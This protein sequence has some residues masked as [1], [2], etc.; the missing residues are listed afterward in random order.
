M[1]WTREQ[2]EAIESRG[3]NLLLAA[4]AGSGKTAVLV[5]R[6]VSLILKDKVDVESLLVMT[7][8]KA[9]ASE[10]KER[11]AKRLEVALET[12]AD[13]DTIRLQLDKIAGAQISTIHSFCSRL[14]RAS[15]QV[16]GIDPASRTMDAEEEQMMLEEELDLLFTRLYAQEADWFVPLAESFSNTR[17]DEGFRNLMI[18]LYD[19]MQ[20]SPD[21]RAW[22]EEAC[23][24]FH[25]QGE[26]LDSEYIQV[27]KTSIQETLME[28]VS[29]LADMRKLVEEEL[30]YLAAT[31]EADEAL[32]EELSQSL[33]EDFPSF[34]RQASSISWSRQKAKPKNMDVDE[35][36][37]AAHDTMR[38][39]LK[40]QVGDELGR[41]VPSDLEQLKEQVDTVYLR[42]RDLAEVAYDFMEQIEERKKAGKLLSF[43]D[44]EHYALRALEN[45]DILDNIREQYEHVFVDE[46]QDTSL[47]QEK[48]VRRIS[49]KDNLF[50]VG[51]V[52]QSIYRFRGAA[53]EVFQQKKVEYRK[54]GGP[55]RL[56]ALNQNFRSSLPVVNCVNHIFENLMTLSLGEID[57]TEGEALVYGANLDTEQRP[58]S[59]HFIDKNALGLEDETFY[60][61]A[62]MEREAKVAAEL[63]KKEKGK[64]FFDHKKGKMRPMEWR[65]MVV[66]LRAKKNWG[67]KY[68]QALK[69]AQVPVYMD[70]PMGYFE[71]VEIRVMT[72]ILNLVDNKDQD[73][74]WLS[75]L[76]SPIIGMSDHE[77][78]ILFA[79]RKK[80]SILDLVY[81]H[82]DDAK[83]KR[84]TS[85]VDAWQQDRERI[86]VGALVQK[87]LQDSQWLV[88]VGA[89]DAAAQRRA[90]LRLFLARAQDYA[91]KSYGGLRGFLHLFER[92]KNKELDPGVAMTA[93]EKSDVVRIV[94][95][96]G[97]KGLEYPLVLVG[98]TGKG[99]NA[100]ESQELL[101]MHR[102]LGLGPEVTNLEKNY[103]MKTSDKYRI[104]K[105]MRQESRSEELR[106]L[107]VAATR[108]KNRLLFL[109]GLTRSQ[110]E[111]LDNPYLA[112]LR[113]GNSYAEWFYPLVI[114]KD[115]PY[116]RA[117]L[118]D[119]LALHK[120]KQVR[121]KNHQERREEIRQA[122]AQAQAQAVPV[123]WNRFGRK[124]EVRALL[125]SKLGVTDVFRLHNKGLDFY[126]VGKKL[127][128]RVPTFLEEEKKDRGT[129]RGLIL[130]R[131]MQSI[132]FAHVDSLQDVQA[133]LDQMVEHEI[134][135]PEERKI[136]EASKILKFFKSDLGQRVLKAKRVQRELAFNIRYPASE[137]FP[138]AKEEGLE[139]DILLQGVMDLVAEE[140]DGFLLLDYKTDR[141]VEDFNNPH[142]LSY[143]KYAK[144]LSLY[145]MALE[146]LGGKKVKQI[147]LYLFASDEVKEMEV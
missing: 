88:L 42:L 137:V 113:K 54:K 30:P 75:F 127:E 91:R 81:E 43:S 10:M 125:P 116:Y 1:N 71:S 132:D 92:M 2:G 16:L 82:R 145:K 24:H 78:A 55:G 13:K 34:M 80:E 70:R 3:E 126:R 51:D 64:L 69:Q 58:V 40:K 19:F 7:F 8:T 65:D 136:V 60:D 94:T 28:A 102:S 124:E 6:V 118:V 46:Y 52:K 83:I 5:E 129:A 49:R 144:Q 84:A 90:N 138:E 39:A 95:V 87:I 89:M 105:K 143:Q 93:G 12:E 50:M 23:E 37:K 101:L 36:A 77:L 133:Q 62:Y 67:D 15:S 107:Y 41:M 33:A 18:R 9:A 14:V 103:R 74:A 135:L 96:H 134:L 72:E 21:P 141:S 45:Q 142:S 115:S 61:L 57:Y 35:R 119:E 26:L 31:Q 47:V 48:I 44:L 121:D 53:P 117:S 110:M 139:E 38:K 120:V 63:L 79:G 140:E 20:G 122:L 108:A 22:M 97:S 17:N 128:T 112:P 109:G 76:R 68:V 131:V 66:I 85:L 147:A 106:V 11:I 56:I 25:I 114:Q 29:L 98:G 27:L 32:I 4:A 104:A 86:D 59:F 130:H 100:R 123:N 146:K 99:F 111:A 73:Y